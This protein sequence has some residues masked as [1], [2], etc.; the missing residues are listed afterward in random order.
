VVRICC[1]CYEAVTDEIVRRRREL[2]DYI[3]GHQEFGSS[4]EPLVLEAGAPES[5]RRMSAAADLVGVGPMAAVAGTMAQL[6]AEAGLRAGAEEV[7]VENG[8]DIYL[9]VNEP[10]LIGLYSGKTKLGD[11]LGFLVMPEDGPMALCSSSG[12]M[13]HSMSM[14]TCDLA[15]VSARSAALAD[16]AATQAANLVR[17]EKD[18]D[19]ALERIMTVEG[20]EGVMVVKGDRVGMAGKL[21]ELVRLR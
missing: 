3:A 21:P 5:A 6:A 14:G 19:T 4:L 20:I 9:R 8:G 12:M 17:K 13:G 7:I 18:V 16:A 15:T 1:R 10:G 2:D 11:R